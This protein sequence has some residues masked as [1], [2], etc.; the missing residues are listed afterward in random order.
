MF[1]SS[2]FGFLDK[3]E[4]EASSEIETKIR[5]DWDCG[6]WWLGVREGLL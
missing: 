6:W 2:T 5:A 4:A 1:H 3:K